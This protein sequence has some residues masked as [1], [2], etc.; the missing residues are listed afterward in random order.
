PGRGSGAD[1]GSVRGARLSHGLSLTPAWPE[2]ALEFTN[3]VNGF[4]GVLDHVFVDDRALTV[5]SRIPG[6]PLAEVRGSI[7][8][9]FPTRCMGRT[10]WRWHVMWSGS[11]L[12]DRLHDHS[13]PG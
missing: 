9:A 13:E 4:S 2:G 10:T 3:A 6:V 12:P 11:L 1:S 5:W 7:M 8:A